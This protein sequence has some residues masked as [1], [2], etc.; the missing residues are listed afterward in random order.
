M[1]DGV[2]ANNREFSLITTRN[3]SLQE[4]EQ[5]KAFLLIAV[6]SGV[7]ALALA[8]FGAWPVLPF[9]GVEIGALYIAV[10]RFARD[11][12]DY[13]QL[14]IRGDR[15]LVESRLHGHLRRFDA[16][17]YWTQLVVVEGT[18][19]MQLTLRSHGREIKFGTFLSERARI[20]AAREL[21]NQLRVER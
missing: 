12:G 4:H 7:I 14:M 2:A 15:L 19:G 21:R 11:A 6:I 20:N 13:E 16:N 18:G 10:R 1:Q 3:C 8:V 5:W 17:R 9:A